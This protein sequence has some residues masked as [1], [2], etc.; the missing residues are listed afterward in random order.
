VFRSTH[1]SLVG[2]TFSVVALVAL[3]NPA[4]SR[5]TVDDGNEP[6]PSASVATLTPIP[7]TYPGIEL[8]P[9]PPSA[10]VGAVERCPGAPASLPQPMPRAACDP[11]RAVE[12]IT[13]MHVSDMHGHWHSYMGGRSPYALLRAHAD[14]RRLET[15]GRVLF[16]DGGD[17]LEKGSMADFTSGG[18]ATVHL[19]DY[20]GL[21]ARTIGNHD[22]AY[23]VP[24]VL[25]QAKSP[26]HPLLASNLRYL[27]PPGEHET[28]DAHRYVIFE[29]GCARVGVFGLLINGYDET[30]ERVDAPYL[31]AFAQEH[32]ADS[33]DRFVTT[34][35]ALV[36]ELREEQKV[37]AVIAVNHLG[38]FRDRILIEQV[39]GL[40][41]VISAH[42]HM[43]IQGAVPARFGSL[44]NTGSFVGGRSEARFGEVTLDVD[45]RT[46]TAKVSAAISR[47][48]DDLSEIDGA[49]QG[50]VQRMLSCFAPD[51]DVPIADLVSPVQRRDP[52]AWTPL[53]DAALRRKFPD[54]SALLYEAW[55]YGGIM[56]ED[57]ARGPITRQ[58]IFDM[59]YP[60]KQR[61]G[62]PGFTAFVGV[63]VSGASLRDLCTAALHEPPY[64]RIHRVCPRVNDI[65]PEAT[66]RV[67]MERRPLH[68]PS[69]A[70][71]SPPASFPK[72]SAIATPPVEA[73]E[74]LVD[75][76][77]SKGNACVA[78]DTDQKLPCR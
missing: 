54:A 49:V 22:F 61:A 32:D 43:P 72:P 37:D 77:V 45:V 17:D 63:D 56:K 31:G 35:S 13:V 44:V 2:I 69:Y 70:F 71:A 46:K 36:R 12:R 8:P 19:L 68:A 21:D 20:L 50:E 64:K 42:D 76:A 6:A 15:G 75:L 66:Y 58:A 52:D 62:G 25:R 74:A 3:A 5:R 38:T 30:D 59:A 73:F 47:S 55:G 10:T 34:A 29:V 41:L 18:E 4:C 1:R 33:T 28:F 24:N 60:E 40:D 11:S 67:V 57:L 16:F 26:T 23:G 27:P 48:V 39:P 51:A 78:L 53:L 14:R 9:S 7:Y 65:R